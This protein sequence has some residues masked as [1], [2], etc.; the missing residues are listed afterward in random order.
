MIPKAY[1]LKSYPDHRGELYPLWKMFDG[2]TVSHPF[3]EDRISRSTYGVLRG[4]HGDSKTWKLMSCLYGEI[5]LV[6]WDVEAKTRYDYLVSDKNKL[7]VLIPPNYLNAHQC[8]SQECILFYKWSEYYSGPQDQWS[9]RW[10]DPSIG[11]N[12]ANPPIL[13]E[14]DSTSRTLNEV[15]N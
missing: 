7:Q 4:F 13:S 3:V 5:Q 15:F 8:L 14:R 6:L 12:W 2:E 11:F 10:D 9:V 1:Y